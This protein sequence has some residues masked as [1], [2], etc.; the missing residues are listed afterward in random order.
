MARRFMQSGHR[1]PKSWREEDHLRTLTS[2]ESANRLAKEYRDNKA[3]EKEDNTLILQAYA[4]ELFRKY[5]GKE[6][7]VVEDV[8]AEWE[9]NGWIRW[10]KYAHKDVERAL[11]KLYEERPE[12]ANAD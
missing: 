5:D 1:K 9:K 7:E 2:F 10:A 12:L 8:I 4:D 6:L 3:A 11:A